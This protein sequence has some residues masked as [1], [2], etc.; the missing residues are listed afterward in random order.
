MTVAGWFTFCDVF[1][2]TLVAKTSNFS[3][4]LSLQAREN[5][6][7]VLCKLPRRR[8]CFAVDHVGW[9]LVGYQPVRFKAAAMGSGRA[10]RIN[11]RLEAMMELE[12]GKLLGQARVM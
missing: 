2:I 4:L 11:D 1:N 6:G 3:C 12:L 10:V 7:H 8:V 9:Q 5:L